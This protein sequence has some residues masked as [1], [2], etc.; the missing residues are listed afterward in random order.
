SVLMVL[1]AM[2]LNPNG[3]VD[4]KLL[5]KPKPEAESAVAYAAPEGDVE[6]ALAALWSDVLGVAQ[7]GRHDNFFELGGHSLLAMQLIARI[8]HQFK[9]TMPVEKIFTTTSLQALAEQIAA[10]QPANG[11]I[12]E[13]LDELSSFLD[14]L[15]G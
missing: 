5:P 8:N 12:D 7:V 14:A 4:R 13:Q 6:Q 2:P 9:L 15:E 11:A 1:E 10:Q 3:K